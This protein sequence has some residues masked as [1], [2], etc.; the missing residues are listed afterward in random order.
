MQ[1]DRLELV[2]LAG[3]AAFVLALAIVIARPP[4]DGYEISLYD[5][6]PA[7]F[8]ALI[9][10]ALSAGAVILVASTWNRTDRV[11]MEGVGLLVLTNGLLTLLPYLRGYRLYGRADAL[12][13]L[14]YVRNIVSSGDIG[15]NIYS[16]MHV[17]VLAVAEAAGAQPMAVAMLLTAVLS[18][19]YFGGMFYLMV[20]LFEDRERVLF[21]LPFVMLPVL[22]HAHVGFRP[23]DWSLMLIPI[24]LYLFTKSQQDP[25]PEVRA[26]FVISLVAILLYHPL[27]GLFTIV[28]F[29]IYLLVRYAPQITQQYATS[30]NVLSLSAMVFLVWYSSFAGIVFRFQRIYQTLFGVSQDQAPADAYVDAINQAQP[31]LQQTVRVVT[32]K[33]GIEAVLFALGFAFIGLCL[34]LIFRGRYSPGIATALLLPAF[35]LFSLGG[36]LFLT[37]DLIVPHDRPFQIAKIGGTVLAGQLCY[38][39][40]NNI[41]FTQWSTDVQTPFRISVVSVLLV[42]ALLSTFS[43]YP[44]PLA[45]ETNHQ[46]TAMELEGSNW[47]MKHGN[48]TNELVEFKLEYKRFYHAR[49]GV[50]TAKPFQGQ[51]PPSHFN[52]TERP[53]FGQSYTTDQYLT[54]NRLGRIVYPRNFANYPEHWQFRPADFEQL[55]RDRTVAHVYDNGEYDQ[56]LVDGTAEDSR[57]I[58]EPE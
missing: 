41:D 19:I 44:S 43:L 28:I 27:T 36:L 58:S 30:T 4:A 18:G 13:H 29:A 52:Y 16:P 31:P 26:P 56:Y 10:A 2:S 15:G 54:V 47:L 1:S 50:E 46:V 34:L 9:V 14:G 12:S 20:Y 25:R 11:W 3:L 32:F 40:W 55:R 8:W 48:E 39:L 17:L 7:Y 53:S 35:L 57:P 23:F 51:R 21:G 38:L 42:L 45:T 6:Y 22:G 5:A 33:Y 49:H 37:M 24:V